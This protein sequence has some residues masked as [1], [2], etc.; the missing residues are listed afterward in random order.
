MDMNKR[1]GEW[2]HNLSGQHMFVIQ[3]VVGCF[4]DG[5]VQGDCVYLPPLYLN[6]HGLGKYTP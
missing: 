1:V 5:C 2:S 6:H 3:G 4:K